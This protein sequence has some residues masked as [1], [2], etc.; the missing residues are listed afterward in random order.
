MRFS[1][2]GAPGCIGISSPLWGV[3]LRLQGRPNL[4]EKTSDD[5]EKLVHGRVRRAAERPDGVRPNLPGW[6]ARAAARRM[7]WCGG[8][9]AAP[10]DMCGWQRPGVG[11]SAACALH[12]SPGFNPHLPAVALLGSHKL[13]VSVAGSVY[14]ADEP[15]PGSRPDDV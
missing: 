1:G 7:E 2:H 9:R 4:F 3:S 10:M 13:W 8:R 5:G 6:C 11:I 15:D 12:D 14:L